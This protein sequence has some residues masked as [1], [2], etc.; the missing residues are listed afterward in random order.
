MLHQICRRGRLL[1]FMKDSANTLLSDSEGLISKALK[2]FNIL[3]RPLNTLNA[4]PQ[5][6]LEQAAGNSQ[7]EALSIDHYNQILGYLNQKYPATPL[8]HYSQFPHPINAEILPR[9]ASPIKHITHNGR[10]YSTFATHPGNSSISIQLQNGIEVG[11]IRSIWSQILLQK[12]HIFIFVVP[13]LR[14]SNQDG[15]KNP[16]SSRGGF[17]AGLVYS[18]SPPEGYEILIEVNQILAHVPY[19]KRPAGTFGISE[20]TMVIINSLNR[21]QK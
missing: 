17:S 1:A 3:P 5:S 10:P 4:E 9:L 11:F 20:E 19:Y 14:L 12:E 8:R 2:M 21:A 16:Y 13:H 7:G 18:K 6:P 15:L